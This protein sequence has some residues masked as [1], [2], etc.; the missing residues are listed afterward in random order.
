MLEL[1]MPSSVDQISCEFRLFRPLFE[2][3]WV[4]LHVIVTQADVN[5]ILS[6]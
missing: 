3:V 2:E 4:A 6:H 1:V 5:V